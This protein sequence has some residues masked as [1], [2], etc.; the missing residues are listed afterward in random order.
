MMSSTGMDVNGE[1]KKYVGQLTEIV[2]KL[3]KAFF[4]YNTM[5]VEI[6]PV[7]YTHL[8]TWTTFRK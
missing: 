5:L 1:D 3:Y 6:N 7:S 8:R 2:K 4:D